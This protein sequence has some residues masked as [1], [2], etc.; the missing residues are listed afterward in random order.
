MNTIYKYALRQEELQMI[1]MPA[2]ARVLTVQVQNNVPCLWAI[3][4]PEEKKMVQRGFAIYGT[5]YPMRIVEVV[6]Y[7]G[8]FQLCDGSLVFHV[9]TDGKEYAQEA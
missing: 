2:G 1:Q 4:D 5:G 7:V 8:T 9:F 3:V 6:Q